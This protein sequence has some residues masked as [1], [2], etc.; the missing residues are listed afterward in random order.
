M[1]AGTRLA[2]ASATLTAPDQETSMKQQDESL[3]ALVAAGAQALGLTVDPA[4][5][6]GVNFHLRLLLEHA[7]RVED[8][9]LADEAEPAP[10]F[11]A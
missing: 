5:R 1:A 6:D 8:F 7:A 10:V 9:P 2:D 3:E 11:D 4:W